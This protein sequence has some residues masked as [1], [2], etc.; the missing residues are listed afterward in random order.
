MEEKKTDTVAQLSKIGAEGKWPANAERDT[1]R[2]IH[3]LGQTLEACIDYK[4]V[5]M[6]NPSTLEES[7]Q[8]LPMILPHQPCLALWNR[9]EA[10]FRR[11]LFGTLTDIEIKQF[12]DH[13]YSS[14]Q[15][16]R[17][18]PASAWHRRER[19]AGVVSYGDEVQAYKN[20]ECGAVSV[21]AWS[22]ELAY[23]NPPLLRYFN[24]ATWSEHHESENTYSD[25][26]RHVVESFK[27]L[28]DTSQDWPWT[29]HG[30]YIAFTA[31]Q[32]DL[33]WICDRMNGFHNF[34]GNNCCSRC[35]CVKTSDDVM[36]TLTNFSEDENQ[37]TKCNYDGVD[38]AEM[39]SPLFEL[40]LAIE[41]V[42][43]D[44][45]HSQLLG[46]G[47]TANGPSENISA[48]LFFSNIH[49]LCMY[50]IIKM[51]FGPFTIIEAHAWYTYANQVSLAICRV[52]ESILTNWQWFCAKRTA[53]F[54]FS[55]RFTNWI[56]RNQDSHLLV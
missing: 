35:H 2:L 34:R 6:V 22:A 15:W 21:I 11:C 47:K 38:L 50:A 39:F 29:S 18:H 4:E 37:F 17:D 30:Y 1:H 28:A 45:A 54:F 31:C 48:I 49:V 3:R 16:F 14:S 27:L 46:S 52:L 8:L 26:I 33:K 20:S 5:R 42:Q 9:S 53:T 13:T 55:R 41:R 36:Q 19:L 12:W 7:V 43:H 24:I 56:A 23:R 32:G 25:A 51:K 40:P 44:V 10:V